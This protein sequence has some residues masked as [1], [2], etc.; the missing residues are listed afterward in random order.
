MRDD[1]D[2]EIIKDKLLNQILDY[3][4]LSY[5]NYIFGF[6]ETLEDVISEVEELFENPL[7]FNVDVYC[8]NCYYSKEDDDD[9]FCRIFNEKKKSYS[10][11]ICD[12][13]KW[14]Y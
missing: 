13:F 1:K 2:I 8:D 12:N 14:K 10:P 9:I 7:D 6:S 11:V 4:K 3:D 5:S